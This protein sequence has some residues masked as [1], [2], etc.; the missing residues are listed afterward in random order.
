MQRW[1]N[2]LLQNRE[3]LKQPE[4]CALPPERPQPLSTLNHIFPANRNT[5]NIKKKTIHCLY[6]SLPSEAPTYRH[7]GLA[8][9]VQ[10]LGHRV[11][12]VAAD[13]EVAH[14]HLAQSVDENIGGLHVCKWTQQ[15]GNKWE[16]LQVEKKRSI[17][18]QSEQ[19][20]PLCITDSLL[21]RCSSALTICGANTPGFN[22]SFLHNYTVINTPWCNWLI[23]AYKLNAYCPV[24]LK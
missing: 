17:L 13:A 20:L 19:R 12:Q 23:P 1:G 22:M 11:H 7:V 21:C 3:E 9:C 10:C 24:R 16:T 5:G 8:A 14:F 6:A 18:H 2:W 15:R 4:H